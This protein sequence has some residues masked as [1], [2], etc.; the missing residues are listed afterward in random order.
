MAKKVV[1]RDRYVLATGYPCLRGYESWEGT[2]Y[3]GMV[4]NLKDMASKTQ[5]IELPDALFELHGVP[6]YRLVLERVRRK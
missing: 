3:V 4:P 6:R 2:E 5:P 1:Y